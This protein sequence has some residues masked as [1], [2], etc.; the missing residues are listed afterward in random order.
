MELEIIRWLRNRL[1]DADRVILGPGDDAAV[2]A[3]KKA[4]A[5][6]VACD[7]IAEG[8][9][10]ILDDCTFEQVGHKALA[11]NL[12]D[13]AAMAATPVAATISLILPK[14]DPLQICQGITEGMLNLASRH[15]VS[16]VGGDITIWDGPLVVTVNVIGEPG[17]HGTWRR[18]GAV[19]GDSLLVTGS[20]GGS[21]L[22]HHLTFD[23]RVMESAKLAS[24]YVVNAA[25]DI[26]DGLAIDTHRLV[27]ESGLGAVLNLDAIPVSEAAVTLSNAAKDQLSPLDHALQD[28]ED[29]ELLFAVDHTLV[30]TILA[31]EQLGCPVAYIGTVVEDRGLW[32]RDTTGKLTPLAAVGYLHGAQ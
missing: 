7:T 23:P 18:D 16:L 9:D 12:S 26:S 28:G 3:W 20:L 6:V 17:P 21:I 25:I 19:S 1:P 13:L 14:D 30:E 2:V 8:L 22:G 15:A 32:S 29:F 10:F 5:A 24:K 27:N 11:I 31:D 4:S